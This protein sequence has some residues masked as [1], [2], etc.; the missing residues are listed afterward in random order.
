MLLSQR[1]SP[2]IQCLVIQWLCL[3]IPPLPPVECRQTVKA[4]GRI[5]MPLSQYFSP[6]IQSLLVQWF[7]LFIGTLLYKIMGCPM[8]EASRYLS[9]DMHMCNPSRT[10]EHMRKEILT[11][12]PGFDFLRIRKDSI[13]ELDGSFSQ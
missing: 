3:L 8:K 7:R 5:G 10:C 2:D 9:P 11:E 6:D 4:R 12:R 1:F 13:H